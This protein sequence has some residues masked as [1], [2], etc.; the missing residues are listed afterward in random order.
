M[1]VHAKEMETLSV[2]CLRS[3]MSITLASKH[4]PS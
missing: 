1:S 2:E 4:F 3:R